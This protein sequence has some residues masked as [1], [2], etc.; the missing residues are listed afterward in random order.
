M[1]DMQT[2]LNSKL[3][4]Q[5]ND[6]YYSL[7]EKDQKAVKLLGGFAA[8][9]IVIF[10]LLL[11]AVSYSSDAQADYRE[12]SA[13]L[14][15]MQANKHLVASGGSRGSRDPGQSLLG[16]ANRSSK[17][18]NINFKRYEPVGDS[19]L[20]LWLEQISFNNMI[21]WLERLDKQFGIQVKEISVESQNN[22]NGLVT[23]RLVLQG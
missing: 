18:F 20:R 10:G 15:W 19:G 14:A 13:T 9:M 22:N 12:N 21:L 6:Y 4:V 11:P 16:I 23:V 7:P 17:S 8:I 5:A 3:V 2:I 1:M